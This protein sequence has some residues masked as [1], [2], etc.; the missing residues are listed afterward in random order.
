MK[1]TIDLQDAATAE[2]D[3]AN[4]VP[5]KKIPTIAEIE[6][7]INTALKHAGFDQESVEVTLRVVGEAES[8]QLNDQYRQ[9][10]QPTNILSFPFEAPPQLSFDLLGD[11]VVCLPVL[12]QEA[13]QQKKSL[14]SHWAHLVVHGT[15]HLLGYDHLEPEQADEMENLEI[16]TLQS[17]DFDN[18]YIV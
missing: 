18:P 1:I 17:L 15:L 5:D 2:H 7:W 14:T 12:E 4:T 3:A 9:K 10:N 11:L 8:Q 6:R 13:R 16:A